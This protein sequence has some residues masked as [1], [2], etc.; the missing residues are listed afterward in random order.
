MC[1]IPEVPEVD[2]PHENAD[3]RDDF[4]EHVS[5]VVQLSFQGSFLAN[6]GRNGLVNVAD[7]C[8]L[9]GK[10]N[11]RARAPIHDCCALVMMDVRRVWRLIG[12]RNESVH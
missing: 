9:T 7:G 6:L 3:D 10:D 12:C 11:D 5:E 2:E 8:A 1:G 4:S